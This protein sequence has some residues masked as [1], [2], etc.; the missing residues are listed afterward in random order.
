MRGELPAGWAWARLGEVWKEVRDRSEPVD[1]GDLP[2]L[3]LEHV[4]S[5]TTRIR[6]Q[7]R[8]DDVRSTVA[9]FSAG[10][11]LYGRLRP[12]LNKAIRAPFDGVASTEFLV[13]REA[14]ALASPFLLHLLSSGRVV[15]HA[16]ANSSGVN[17]PRVSAEKLGQLEFKLPPLPEQH[18]IVTKLD[19]LF[20]ELDAG[21]AALERAQAKL[22]RYRASVL[23]AAVEGRLTERWREQNPP[24]ETGGELLARILVER[25]RRWEEGQLAAFEAKGRK[26]PKDWKKKYKEPVA[27]DTDGLPELPEGWCWATVDQLLTG[28]EAGRNFRCLERPPRD[29]EMGV[30]KVSAVSWGEFLEDESK[31][32]TD[33]SKVDPRFL[34]RTGDLL[35]SRANTIELVGACV[36]VDQLS[37]RLMLSDKILRLRP[38]RV[39]PRWL[40][41][42]L[43]S[44]WGRREIERLATGNQVSMRNISQDSIRS[45]RIPLAP[46]EEI[47][48]A[49]DTAHRVLDM[50]EAAAKLVVSQRHRATHLRQSILSA[51][52]Q[53]RLVPQDPSD[54]PASALLA[55]IRAE[56]EKA[57]SAL[58]KGP[59]D[60]KRPAARPRPKN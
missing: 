50:A 28:I 43:R 27:P 42:V 39:P 40:L 60:G 11:V 14:P 9:V 19:E 21:V 55:R 30:V 1:A 32:C 16:H 44:P 35:I 37:R 59:G 4:E 34:I 18:R 22:E 58:E 33:P 15:T 8:A 5:G 12:Y 57:S 54:E 25:R 38:L 24:T 47:D 2:Y 56:R 52:F 41:N 3:G 48:Q 45:I 7:G 17:L 29:G 26:P 31:T 51:A 49:C 20:S 23:K 36:I 53:G 6:G 13:F 46:S 10:D